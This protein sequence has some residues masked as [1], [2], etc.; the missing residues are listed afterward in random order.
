MYKTF[1]ASGAIAAVGALKVSDADYMQHVARYGRDV[2]STAEMAER[3]ARFAERSAFIAEANARSGASFEVA[4]SAFSDMTEEEIALRFSRV[5]Q[6]NSTQP[7]QRERE[8]TEGS[9][10]A[11]VDWRNVSGRSY[12]TPV[13]DQ[14]SCAASWAFAT[15]GAAE[16]RFAIDYASGEMSEAVAGTVD[17]GLM[18]FSEQQLLDCDTDLTKCAS[19][20][21]LTSLGCTGGHVCSAHGYLADSAYLTEDTVYAYTGSDSSTGNMCGYDES[22]ST[23]LKLR[24]YERHTTTDVDAIKS[25]V[26]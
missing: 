22:S 10:P 20:E 21:Q 19:G 12:I 8:L 2:Q 14:Q 13:K 24:G 11:S 18:T 15:I 3:K 4:H 25:L 5:P 9:H 26:A 1:V 16:A 17:N 23:Y 7:N 6:E